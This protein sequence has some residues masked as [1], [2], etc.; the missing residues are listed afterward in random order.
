MEEAI[1]A[2]DK[3]GAE[4][5]ADREEAPR[6]AEKLCGRLLVVSGWNKAAGIA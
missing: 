5:I 2:A 4:G 1:P 6:S 3:D